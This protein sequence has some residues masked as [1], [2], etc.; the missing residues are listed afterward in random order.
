MDSAGDACG[1]LAPAPV[2]VAARLVFSRVVG[3]AAA[4]HQH[5]TNWL[6]PFG[7]GLGVGPG[8]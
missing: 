6:G 2:A 1:P 7:L 3:R 4:E 8:S 5:E